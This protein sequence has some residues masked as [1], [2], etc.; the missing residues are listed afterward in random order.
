[1]TKR[2]WMRCLLGL[3]IMLGFSMAKAQKISGRVVAS[4]TKEALAFVNIVIQPEGTGTYSDEDGNFELNATSSNVRMIFSLLGYETLEKDYTLSAPLDVKIELKPTILELNEAVVEAKK[5]NIG[6]TIMKL[7]I[8]EK[9]KVLSVN[10]AYR[11]DTYLQTNM[12]KWIEKS[13]KDTVPIVE[14]YQPV[15]F[16]ESFS[17][18][19]YLDGK[20]KQNIKAERKETGD[21][22]LKEYGRMAIDW[23]F[24]GSSTGLIYN[25]IEYFRNP[26]DA[27]IDLYENQINQTTLSDRPITSPLSNFA[28]LNYNFKLIAIDDVEGDTTFTIQVQPK[29]KESP[30][31]EG[32]LKIKQ[33][34]YLLKSATLSLPNSTAMRDFRFEIRYDSIGETNWRPTYRKFTYQTP[35][36]GSKYQVETTVTSSNFDFQPV[37]EKGF[38][39][40]ELVFYELDALNRDTT[41]LSKVRPAPLSLQQ[42]QFVTKQDSVWLYEHSEA[43]YRIQDS[44]Y[45]HNTIVDFLYKGIGW[46]RRSKGLTLYFDSVLESIQPLGVGGYR[47]NL[48]GS[49]DKEFGSA[50]SLEIGYRINYG[51]NNQDWKGRVR[52]RYTYL[53]QR[54]SKFSLSFGDMYE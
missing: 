34:G 10:R 24:S 8:D 15:Y 38:F 53:P 28:T 40:N 51:F 32:E 18:L 52:F 50:N 26:I 17:R 23:S 39:N 43:Y 46:K 27:E 42:K 6:K 31:F 48:G 22:D 3:T 7:V 44:I 4:D 2:N 9:E 14:G 1:M 30:L 33:K 35:L 54:F 37:F 19:H 21:D 5:E 36:K 16:Y 11:C 49:I 12:E 47:H 45:N 29:F 25:P 41:L 20:Y 13:K